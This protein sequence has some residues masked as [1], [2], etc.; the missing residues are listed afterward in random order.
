MARLPQGSASG[1]YSGRMSELR[2]MG[3]LQELGTV[4]CQYTGNTVI[5]WDVTTDLPRKLDK[6]T[7]KPTRKRLEQLRE[8]LIEVYK[9]PELPTKIRRLI[10]QRVAE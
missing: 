9:H 4:E 5:L 6:Q 7:A 3:V 10:D 8:I 2:D 1:T